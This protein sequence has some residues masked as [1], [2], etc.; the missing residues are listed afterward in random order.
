RSS[1]AHSWVEVFFPG[2]G[3]VV[4]DPTPAAPAGEAGLFSRVNQYLG[5]MELTWNEWVISYDFAHQ[6]LLAQ[7]LQRSSR[8]WGDA[9]RGE[10]ERLR[11]NA[12]RV[13]KKWQFR[14]E[15]LGFLIPASLIGLL[16]LL[17]FGVLGKIA[18]Q[19]R[20]FLQLRSKSPAAQPQL[21]SILYGEFLRLLGRYG[22]RRSESQTPLEFAAAVSRPAVA[23]AVQQFT[24][25]YAQARFG[26]AACDAPR[27]RALLGQI[28]S[29]LRSS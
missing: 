18:R 21:A 9:F 22:F 26:G 7:N 15:V 14:H 25:V 20:L 6:V 27:L 2:S 13:I 10:I 24:Q 5:W 23:A 16:A 11:R 19:L 29:G 17:R 1:D 8:S 12:S 3:W 28:R 4:F